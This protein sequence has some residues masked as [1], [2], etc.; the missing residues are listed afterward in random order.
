[1]AKLTSKQRK[2]LPTAQFAL[3]KERKYP[4]QDKTHA[5][6]ALGR[7]KQHATPAQQRAIK[8]KVCSRYRDLPACKTKK[9]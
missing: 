1:M 3:P 9:K 2:R 8:A 4:I 5:V 6:A 7:S